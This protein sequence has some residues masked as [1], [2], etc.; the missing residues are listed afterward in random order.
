MKNINTPDSK[1]LVLKCLLP[2]GCVQL[3]QNQREEYLAYSTNE[4]NLHKFR[5]IFSYI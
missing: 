1:E 3:M 5:Q 2:K 4:F